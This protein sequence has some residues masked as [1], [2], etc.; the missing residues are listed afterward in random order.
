MSEAR[1]ANLPIADI[2]LGKNVRI[3]LR[4]IDKLTASIRARGVRQPITVVP[5]ETGQGAE[6]L[7]GFR[8]LEAAKRAGLDTIPCMLRHRPRSAERIVD[9]LTENLQRSDM[10]VLE[11]ALAYKEL[12]DA[13]MT[14]AQIAKMAGYTDTWVNRTLRLLAM[15]ECVQQ[16]AHAGIIPATKATDIPMP[17]LT[18]DGATDR[19]AAAIHESGKHGLAE[20]YRG[21]YDRQRATEEGRAPVA[22]PIDKQTAN[23]LAPGMWRLTVL[24]NIELRQPT[25]DCAQAANMTVGDWIDLILREAVGLD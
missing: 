4:D 17:M 24:L 23:R 8:R 3:D 16:A 5:D 19:L 22:A 20:W 14:V 10:T 2:R 21:E 1:F 7:V 9:Q 6:V 13:G 25:L 18:A 12:L 15:P 11:V